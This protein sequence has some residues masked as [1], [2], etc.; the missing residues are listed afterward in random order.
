MYLAI[1]LDN[2][3]SSHLTIIKKFTD[4]LKRGVVYFQGSVMDLND[5]IVSLYVLACAVIFPV[6]MLFVY[7]YMYTLGHTVNAEILAIH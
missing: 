5:A 4:Q 7:M 1:C 3:Y 2:M 6:V